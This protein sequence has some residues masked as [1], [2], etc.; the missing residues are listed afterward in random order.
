MPRLK[1]ATPSIPFQDFVLQALT[2]ENHK[3]EPAAEDG[4]YVSRSTGLGEERFTFDEHVLQRFTQA[5]VF[6]GRV[7]VLYQPG[8]P[9]FERLYSAG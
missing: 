7:P 4:L 3:I 6:M 8:K 9:A 1:P 2:V 5:G